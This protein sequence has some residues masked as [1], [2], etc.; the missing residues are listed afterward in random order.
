MRIFQ[1]KISSNILFLN[2][3]LF[4]MK[5]IDSP[6]CSF[7]REEIETTWHLFRQC[8]VTIHYWKSLQTRLNPSINL[9]DRTPESALLGLNT[10]LDNNKSVNTLINH[11]IL[12]FKK[13]L[14][15]MRLRS[16]PSSVHSIKFRIAQIKKT[17]IQI[18]YY[19]HKLDFHFKKSGDPYQIDT[20][21]KL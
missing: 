21:F 20:F 3:Q 15:E 8:R 1:Y 6:L 18:A 5:V 19:N 9:P 13:S 10:A 4:N 16:V 14:H 7:C 12:I 2:A 11:L 17:K